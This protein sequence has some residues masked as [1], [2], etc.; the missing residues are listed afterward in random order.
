MEVA[1]KVALKAETIMAIQEEYFRIKSA[2]FLNIIT[3]SQS[4]QNWFPIDGHLDGP[5]L[6]VLTQT[7]LHIFCKHNV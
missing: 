3:Q 5:T 1:N 6:M 2:S 7:E 4:Y